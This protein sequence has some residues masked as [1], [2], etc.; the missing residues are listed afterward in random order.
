[1]NSPVQ[2]KLFYM[3]TLTR[4][5]ILNTDL[6][7]EEDLRPLNVRPLTTKG[8]VHRTRE[9]RSARA[10]QP[11]RDGFCDKWKDIKTRH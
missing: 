2:V 5:S 4:P 11:L 6:C 7:H 1:M 10:R 8:T 3:E 9:S